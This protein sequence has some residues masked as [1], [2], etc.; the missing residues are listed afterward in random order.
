MMSELSGRTLSPILSAEII[1]VAGIIARYYAIVFEAVAAPQNAAPSEGGRATS[2]WFDKPHA[3]RFALIDV[4]VRALPPLTAEIRGRLF[5]VAVVIE[6]CNIL[7]TCRLILVEEFGLPGVN[8]AIGVATVIAASN[9]AS[10]RKAISGG[11]TCSGRGDSVAITVP[12]PIRVPCI[13]SPAA[14]IVV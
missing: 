14:T 13:A 5:P 4:K 12:I 11:T 8:V 3:G 7:R 6:R 1:V 2:R 9:E 10:G